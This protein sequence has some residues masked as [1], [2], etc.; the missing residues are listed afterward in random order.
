AELADLP[1]KL[2]LP[3]ILCCREA[4]TQ[5]E[6][7][8]QLGWSKSTLVRR[9]EQ[10]RETLARRLGRKGFALSLPLA[11]VL[12]SDCAVSASLPAKL[13]AS[14]CEAAWCVACGKEGPA[15]LVSAKV[16]S[17]TQGALPTMFRTKFQTIIAAALLAG[18][19]TG[20]GIVVRQALG[21]NAAAQDP[22]APRLLQEDPRTKP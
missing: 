1:E 20:A 3:L 18:L 17:L 16:A 11:A 8:N 14:T 10:A 9:L 22:Q 15:G 6:A 2:R 19:V 12:I 21:G 13:V 4:R 7:A 5:D